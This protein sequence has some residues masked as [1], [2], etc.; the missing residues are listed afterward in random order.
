MS[1]ERFVSLTATAPARLNGL[2]PRKGAVAVGADADLVVWDPN[3]QWVV[4]VDTGHMGMDYDVYQGRVVQGA[5][6]FVISAGHVVV[7]DGSFD[8]PG[9]IGD[10]LHA[11][12]VFA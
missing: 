4:D 12:P 2:A 10:R 5:P 1:V 11:A 3:R 7:R 9:P 8:D 6:E